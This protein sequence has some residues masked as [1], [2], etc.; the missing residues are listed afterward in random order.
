MALTI[1]QARAGMEEGSEPVGAVVLRDD[2]VLGSGRDRLRQNGDPTA[3]AE[4][5]TYRPAGTQAL[6]ERQGIPVDMLESAAMIELIATYFARFP[7]RRGAFEL[8]DDRL[9][10]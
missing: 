9:L 6:P 1:A 2:A 8:G 4:T 3:H 10:L 5:R 7:A